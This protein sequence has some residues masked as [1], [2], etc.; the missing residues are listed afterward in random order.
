MTRFTQLFQTAALLFV[1]LLVTT[2]VQGSSGGPDAGGWMWADD[3]EPGVDSSWETPSP[4]TTITTGWADEE[5]FAV[6]LSFS[7]TLYGVTSSRVWISS[8]GWISLAD[9]GAVTAPDNLGMPDP[10]RPN[11]L[12][13]YLWDDHDGVG[14]TFAQHGPTPN[15]HL[16]LIR[17]NHKATG[18]LV[19]VYIQFYTNGSV[20]VIYVLD[21]ALGSA[22]VGIENGSGT[23]GTELV[24]DSSS[25]PG[26]ILGAGSAVLFYPL[27]GP[28][29][30]AAS[31]LTC[32]SAVTGTTGTGAAD[33]VSYGC[34]AGTWA[35]RESVHSFTLTGLTDVDLSL[36]GLGLRNADLFVLR[37]NCDGF[38]SCVD[39]GADTLS[40]PMLGSGTYFVVVDGVT[41]ADDGPYD[42]SITC[43]GVSSPIGCNTSFP[44]SASGPSGVDT[45]TCLPGDSSGSEQILTFSTA[46]TQTITA[47]LTPSAPFNLYLEDQRNVT[48][49]SSSCMQGHDDQLAVLNLPPGD[50]AIAIDG[51][52]GSS[53][54]FTVDLTC[55]DQVAAV[56]I[57]CGDLNIPS[58]NTGPSMIDRYPGCS[59]GFYRAGEAFYRFRPATRTI[60][61]VTT[62]QGGTHDL[63][64][65]READAP[66]TCGAWGDATVTVANL[67]PEDHLF[68]VDALAIAG[69]TTLS[70]TCQNMTTTDIAC[71]TTAIGTT[72]ATSAFDG[73]TCLNPPH[74]GG[75]SVF[76]YNNPILQSFAV[77]V[78]ADDPTVDL[79]I[80]ILSGPFDVAAPNCTTGG[81]NI[82]IWQDAPPGEYLIVIDGA[83]ATSGAGFQLVF[84]CG[85]SALSCGAGDIGCNR[86]VSGDT[87]SAPATA[88]IYADAE[89]LFTGGELAYRFTNPGPGAIAASFRLMSPDPLL[90]IMLLT[91]CDPASAIAWDDDSIIMP[92]LD[93]G[94]YW[95]VVDGRAGA[96]GPFQLAGLCG[97]AQLEP[98]TLSASVTPGQ[99]LSEKK[100][101][102]FPP[103]VPFADVMFSLDLSGSMGQELNQVKS[104]IAEVYNEMTQII[105]SLAFGLASFADAGACWTDAAC[106]R[107]V[108]GGGVDFMLDLPLTTDIST[109][110]SVLMAKSLLGGGYERYN[111][112]FYQSY[113]ATARAACGSASATRARRT[114]TSTAASVFPAP[115]PAWSQGPIS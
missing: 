25:A 17:L 1:A 59:T 15:G 73:Y 115:T 78:V 99:C 106:G 39:G 12:I 4:L 104:N 109:V 86:V 92:S 38:L 5:T 103:A 102:F 22:T 111:W 49:T 20:K 63:F 2:P 110:E 69:A 32:P 64:A 87:S 66:D 91:S 112:S 3:N 50:Y 83:A 41:A 7:F 67:P 58:D 45:W 77:G 76:V 105:P 42:L 30:A 90:D 10:I 9:P 88:A 40:L 28:N 52:A 34:S 19:Q 8:N 31:P 18:S 107:D 57:A 72:S 21:P 11:A 35:G 81:D 43:T 6:D 37:A 61:T 53:G 71:E 93:P 108:C 23:V 29:C 95:V 85:S 84:N 101:L 14:S 13:A 48:R 97:T 47:Q 55:S 75:E 74:D 16:L 65:F 54:A 44:G 96:S 51:P 100:Q 114:A 26:V 94:D 62:A 24:N 56:P 60:A 36:T 79:D 80:A 27:S 70:V 89:A 98:P 68:V 113:G 33:V 46:T 82:A